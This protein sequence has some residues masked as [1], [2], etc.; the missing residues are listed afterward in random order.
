[1]IGKLWSWLGNA[2]PSRGLAVALGREH[3]LQIEEHAARAYPEECCGLLVGARKAGIEVHD[4]QAAANLNQE[5]A[6]D[7]YQLDPREIHRADVASEKE[8]FEVIGFYHSHPDHPAAPS[9]TDAELAWPGYVYLISSVSARGAGE[10]R[11]WRFDEETG[12]FDELPM[13]VPSPLALCC[14]CGISVGR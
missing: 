6:R 9:P 11:A 3:L 14:G 12:R 5:R 4:V 13:V 7:R 10:T 2:V 8:G 1:M